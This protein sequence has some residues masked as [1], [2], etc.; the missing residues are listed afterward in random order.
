M[1]CPK[2]HKKKLTNDGK[3]D[4]HENPDDMVDDFEEWP[5]L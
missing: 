2:T 5:T 1:T 3:F 4:R